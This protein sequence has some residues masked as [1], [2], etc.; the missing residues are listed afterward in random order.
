MNRLIDLHLH[1]T[2]SDGIHGAA[3][4]VR[5]AKDSGLAAIAIADHDS[6][7]GVDEALAIAAQLEI[8]VIPAVELSVSYNDYHD[9]HLLGYWIDYRDREFAAMLQLFRDRRES[10][11]LLI[12]DRINQKLHTEGRAPLDCSRVT[13]LAAGALGRPHI[14]RALLEKGYADT[15]QEAFINYLQPCNVPKEYLPFK[16]ALQAIRRVGGIAVL[17]HPQSITRNREDLKRIL[18]D[19]QQQGLDGIEAYNT[20]GMADDD[21]FLRQ[22]ADSLGLAVSGGSDFHGGEEGLVM[23][24]GR[25]NLYLTTDLL[26]GLLRKKEQLSPANQLPERAG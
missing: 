12:V 8:T 4:L 18:Q 14:A 19:M 15:M 26:S 7:D 24:R 5:M 20:M 2:A 17:A 1:T 9:V 23:G 11:G 25:G 3:D 6:V 22:L 16:T 10:R 13:S 21:L